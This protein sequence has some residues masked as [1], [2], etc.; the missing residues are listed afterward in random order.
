MGNTDFLFAADADMQE[1]GDALNSL[2]PEEAGAL[3]LFSGAL[4]GTTVAII[5]VIGIIWYVLLVIARWKIFVKAGEAGWKSLIPIYNGYIQYKITWSTV[6]FWVMAVLYVASIFISGSDGGV[7]QA[8]SA[9]IGLAVIVIAIMASYK[10][11]ASF[12]HGIGFTIGLILLNPI[13]LLILGF[14]DSKYIGPGGIP[15][16]NYY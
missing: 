10:L 15:S 3:G 2:S 8:I 5:A 14:G 11:A 16:G 12:G 13:F 1:L 7:M 9:V 4:V 6:I